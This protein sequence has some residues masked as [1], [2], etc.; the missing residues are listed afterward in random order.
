M[1][2]SSAFDGT[3]LR[4]R[5]GARTFGHYSSSGISS[6]PKRSRSGG[7]VIAVSGLEVHE[8]RLHAPEGV[9]AAGRKNVSSLEESAVHHWNVELLALAERKVAGH[10]IEDRDFGKEPSACYNNAQVA[11]TPLPE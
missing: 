1:G 11:I 9:L 10:S 7:S 2:S 4:V 6:G 8:P 3:P 5:A